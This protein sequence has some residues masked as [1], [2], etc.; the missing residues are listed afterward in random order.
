MTRDGNKKNTSGKPATAKT[1]TAK[2]TRVKKTTAKTEK[3]AKPAMAKAPTQTRE[4]ILDILLEILEKGQHSHIVLRQALEKYQYLPKSDR[5]FITRTVEG[6]I[7][8]L[9]TIDGVLDLCSNTKVK[10]MK[11]VIRTILRMSV[12]QM[13]WMD[14]IPDRAVCS[15]AVNLAEKRH[16]AGLKGF[17]NGVLRSVSRRKEE[18]DFP[19]WEKKYSMPDWL[20]ENWKSQYGS[21]A[22]EQMLQA[23]LAEMP[24]T[25][26]CNLDRAS[27][28]EIRESLEAQGVTVTES[29][30]L[31][32]ALQISGYD[33]LESLD[34]FENGWIQVQD[35][36]SALV[37]QASGV[38]EGEFVLDV[39]GAPGGKSLDLADRL[40]GSG[41]VV[42]RDLTESKIA[43]VEDNIY[44]SGFTNIRAEVWD[45]REFDPE[46][47]NGAD[48]VLADLPC[49]GLGIIGKKPDIKY[50]ASP[51]KIHD[52]AVLQREIL[53]TVTRYVKPGGRLVYS[54]CTISPEENEKQRE[55]ILANFPFEPVDLTDSLGS[56]LA[57]ESLK[58]GYVQ[59]LPGKYP[60]DGF[61]ISVYRR[62][63]D[64][65]L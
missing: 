47:E 39:C 54:T 59:L 41:Q 52:L 35:A 64:E 14:R 17:V 6:T 9:I 38:R 27:L 49:S 40:K 55:W 1:V 65:T 3:T 30:L 18:F 10:K 42:V 61:F 7:E 50:Q 16:F 46:W 8:R 63:E 29:P 24:T 31:A 32:H 20:I 62:K 22:T 15:E 58:D 36:S 37:G 26:R 12:Y 21:K 44:R 53:E 4:L 11:P 43:L 34:A 51:E 60:C 56:V 28:E 23:F 45:A 13:L 25:V 33:Y 57:K 5:A 2:N 19:D 48:L